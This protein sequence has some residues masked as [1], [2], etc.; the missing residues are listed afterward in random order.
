MIT[1]G[2]NEGWHTTRS[3]EAI[4]FSPRGWSDVYAA[5]AGTVYIRNFYTGSW[6]NLMVIQHDD[7]LYTY[8]AHLNAQGIVG[9]G[10][11]VAQGQKIGVVG[12][13]GNCSGTHL[14]FE[15][16]DGITQSDPTNTGDSREHSAR[17]IRGIGWFPWYIN[18]NSNS[19]Y[20]VRA[21]GPHIPNE[22]V[23]DA[24]LTMDWL[25]HSEFVHTQ[26]EKY[27]WSITRKTA[28]S[29]PQA[30]VNAEH[31]VSQGTGNLAIATKPRKYFIHLRAYDAT[32]NEWATE[33]EIAHQG[34]Y[35]IGTGC[36]ATVPGYTDDKPIT[37]SD[38]EE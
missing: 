36:P 18:A 35:N 14:H 20:T 11:P 24:S 4:D 1:N 38:D 22:C 10:T 25:A 30:V 37:E 27:S 3:A 31:G 28:D 8:Y 17:R 26:T 16:R 2:P 21:L 15:A 13:T 9:V 29:T 19:G 7:G 33:D 34:P 6:G 12:C 5:K 32:N 23:N